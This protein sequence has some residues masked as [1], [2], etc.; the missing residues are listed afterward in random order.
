[1]K[2]SAVLIIVIINLYA[3]SKSNVPATDKPV[4]PS[5]STYYYANNHLISFRNFTFDSSQHLASVFLRQND[6]TDVSTGY[7]EIDSGSFHFD[8]DPAANL[9]KG[10]WSDYKK[11]YFGA[12]IVIETHLM[13]YNSQ[14][15]LIKDSGLLAIPG[16][17]PNPPTRYYTYSGNTIISNSYLSGS[18]F[19]TDTLITSNGNV[20]YFNKE[21]VAFTATFSTAS[22]PLYN[23]ELSNSLGAFLLVEGISDFMSKNLSNNDGF[24]W[25]TGGNRKIESGS[26]PTGDYV[27]FTY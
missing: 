11:G 10:Y 2:K 22:N 18:L 21:N 16:Q 6:T 8:I 13:Y 27:T 17:N 20:I 23:A 19:L 12:Q 25:V 5:A 9:P 1:M 3:C 4:F 7:F 15:L 14:D 26:A 24:T